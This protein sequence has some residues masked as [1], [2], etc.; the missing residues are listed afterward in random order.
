MKIKIILLFLLFYIGALLM[1]LP[2]DKVVRFIPENSGVKVAAVSGTLWDGQASQLVYQNRYRL[3]QLDWE[4]NWSLLQPLQLQLDLKFNNGLNA[5]SGN[6]TI[7]F[8]LSDTSIKNFIMNISPAEVLT[9]VSLPVPV[10]VKGDLSLV[11]KTA[12]QGSPY[13]QQLDGYLDWK[14]AKIESEMGNIDLDFAHIDLSCNNGQVTAKLQQ[15][16]QQLNST[17]TV[18]LKEKGIYEIKGLI[19][20]GDKLEPSIKD[21]LSW[22]GVKNQRG[23]TVVTFNG[24]L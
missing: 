20:A 19:K 2:A 17:G 10:K 15:H 14:G 18:L 23:E 9:Y 8:G 16:S 13:C 21:A 7:L 1:T 3:K 4:I 5:M 12:S 22:I 24:K 6:G 11:I